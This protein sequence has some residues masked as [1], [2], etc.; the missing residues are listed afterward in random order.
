M[1]RLL[2]LGLSALFVFSA[3]PARACKCAPPVPGSAPPPRITERTTPNPHLAAF[4]GTVVKSELHGDLVD[5]KEGDLISADLDEATPFMVIS[6]D[7]SRSYPSNPRKTA[8]VR[9]GLGGGDCG[10]SF[11]VGKPYLVDAWEDDHAKFVTSICS[12]TASLEG[13]QSA[14]KRKLV[15]RGGNLR[16]RCCTRSGHAFGRQR[17][18]L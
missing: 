15:R 9:T 18:F 10:Y 16:L 8:E 2:F 3:A 14:K 7:V 6:F 17:L 11:E 12:Q 5:A 1:C 13:D 4:E